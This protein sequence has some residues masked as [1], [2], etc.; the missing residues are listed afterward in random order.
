M[1]EGGSIK[2]WRGY[3]YISLGLAFGIYRGIKVVDWGLWDFFDQ[4]LAICMI[5]LGV[6]L[7]VKR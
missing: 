7:I 6:Y 3:L 2:N 1:A 5:S 4:A